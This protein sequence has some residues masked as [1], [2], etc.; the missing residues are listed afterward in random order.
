MTEPLVSF[1]VPCYKLAHLLP[2]CVN[3]ILTQTY[4]NF[5]VL[6]MDDC[7]PDQTPE[8]ARSFSDSRVRHIRNEPNL[9]HLRN[10]N[11]GIGLSRGKYIW[12]IS[13]DDRL[14]K[15]YVLDRYVRLM[16]LHPRVGYVFCPAVRLDSGQETNVVGHSSRPDQ[17]A[18][19]NGRRFLAELVN[20]NFVVA[21]SVMVRAECYE[22]VSRFPLDM[23]WGGDWYLW[24]VFALHYDVAYL[25]EPMVNYRRHDLS[26]TDTLTNQRLQA[27]AEED[28]ALPWR[29]KQKAEEAG[30]PSIVERCRISI[31]SQYAND[32]GSRKYKSSNSWHEYSL[33]LEEFEQSLLQNSRNPQE[34]K[35]IRA[36]VYAAL[37]DTYFWKRDFAGALHLYRNGLRQDPRML[38]AWAKYLL[39]RAGNVGIRFRECLPALRRAASSV[40]SAG[41]PGY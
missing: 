1:V 20:V 12:L 13:A 18:I 8:V 3:S 25:R 40:R 14:R 9:G 17:D 41:R 22:K 30:Y 27:C 2:E 6:I 11:K 16:E 33:T 5:E 4:G 28:L 26:M 39:L 35:I 29:I 31:A 7:S 32:I 38:Q 15:P 23:P 24:C 34:Q 10:Y 37:A 19:L 36:R 21:P